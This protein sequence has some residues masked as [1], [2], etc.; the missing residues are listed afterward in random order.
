M[1]ERMEL[2]RPVYYRNLLLLFLSALP[3]IALTQNNFDYGIKATLNYTT[4]GSRY[5]KYTGI[6]Q[7]SL[8]IFGNITSNAPCL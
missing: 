6:G 7:Y 8:G 4:I 2:T 1:T 3:F 5:T